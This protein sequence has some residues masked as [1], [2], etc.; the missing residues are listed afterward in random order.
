MAILRVCVLTACVILISACSSS[1]RTKISTFRDSAVPV[2]AGTIKVEPLDTAL[3][4][5][6]EFKYYKEGLEAKL[7]QAGYTVQ[8]GETQYVARLNYN[9]T[10]REAEQTQGTRIMVG[11]GYAPRYSR[12]G[13][14]FSDSFEKRFEFE[15]MLVLV[16]ADAAKAANVTEGDNGPVN[17]LEITARSVGN[18]ESLP[19]V[20]EEMLSAIFQE[21][22]R[23]NGSMRTVKVKGESRC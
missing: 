20:Y 13:L 23:P 7:Q 8:A 17:V 10:R 22:S 4:G 21:L 14:Y 6:L 11:T 1:V 3:K 18:C 2:G 19:I 12:T 15:R 16:I 5:S 9:V